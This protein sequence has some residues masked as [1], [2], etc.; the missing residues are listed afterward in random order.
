MQ[1]TKREIMITRVKQSACNSGCI[2]FAADM[3]FINPFACRLKIAKAMLWLVMLVWINL[4][5]NVN[6]RFL[7][8]AY[9]NVQIGQFD[10]KDSLYEWLAEDLFGVEEAIAESDANT[11][12]DEQQPV[13]CKLTLTLPEYRT[14][15]NVFARKGN[16]LYNLHNNETLSCRAKAIFIPPPNS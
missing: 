3:R 6:D 13:W 1:L 14:P 4:L 12:D 7:H 2:N 16:Q 8:V 10:D 11:D 9:T 5:A 15:L